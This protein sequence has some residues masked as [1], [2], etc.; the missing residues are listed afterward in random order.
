MKTTAML[1]YVA[2]ALSILAVAFTG[3]SGWWAALILTP[4]ALM[5]GYDLRGRI[6]GAH[7]G[8]D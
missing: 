6:G 3:L 2:A 7:A 5:A 1:I 8:R 4:V